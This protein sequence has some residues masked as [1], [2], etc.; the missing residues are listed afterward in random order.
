MRQATV[1]YNSKYLLLF[2]HYRLLTVN[3][4]IATDSLEN[5]ILTVFQAFI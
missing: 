5:Q 3:I 2:T 1:R 4:S